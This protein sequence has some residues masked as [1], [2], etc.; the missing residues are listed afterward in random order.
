ME[1]KQ[2]ILRITNSEFIHL[3]EHKMPK[4]N[5]NKKHILVLK[6]GMNAQSSL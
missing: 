4:Q 3:E 6:R 2:K 5:N 1:N